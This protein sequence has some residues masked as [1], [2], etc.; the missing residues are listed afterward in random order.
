MVLAQGIAKTS[1]DDPELDT[2]TPFLITAAISGVW[3]LVVIF[4]GGWVARIAW[5][6]N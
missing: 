4:L 3:S 2:T 6:G 5:R 1:D